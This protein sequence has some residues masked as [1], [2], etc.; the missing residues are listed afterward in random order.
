[1]TNNNNIRDT[2]VIVVP[3][4]YE[5]WNMAE[6]D[7]EGYDLGDPIEAEEVKIIYER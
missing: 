6:T 7:G 5:P 1:M 2:P 3:K 4:G